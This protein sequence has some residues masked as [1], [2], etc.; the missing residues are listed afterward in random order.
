MILLSLKNLQLVC[1]GDTKY[2]PFPDDSFDAVVVNGVLEWVPSGLPGNPRE[3][4]MAF[5]KE[6]RRV[7]KPEGCLFLGIENRYAWKTWA[8]NPD[9]HTGLRFVP[10]LPRVLDDLY[11]R[12]N[13]KGGYRNY[14]YGPG[15][16]RQLLS[17]C[18]FANT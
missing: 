10:W 14:L 1:A 11:S 2:L 15:Q 18:G 17:E 6:V 8:R 4:Q 5:L 16:Y 9:G 12:V 3:V 13:G 7:L